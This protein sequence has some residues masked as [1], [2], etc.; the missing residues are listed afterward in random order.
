MA[1]AVESPNICIAVRPYVKRRG[2]FMSVEFARLGGCFSRY[3]LA[4]AG[5]LLTLACGTAWTQT[6][7]VG[8]V[9]GQVTDEQGAVIPGTE[10]KLTDLG[11]NAALTT[12]SND[13]GRYTFASVNPGK[14]NV[15]FTKQ[16]FATF[17][18]AQQD[19][20]IGQV[21]TINATLK[22]GTT[23]TTVEVTASSGAELQTM[24]ATVGNTLN[25]QS[26]IL[27]P[28]LGRDVTTLA[29]LQPATT[30][31]GYTAG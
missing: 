2:W 21:L 18:V 1:S 28:N 11:T 29:V 31:G 13:V 17:Q 15:T 22:V 25:G 20:Q 6:S 10:V 19:V 4:T 3:W 14:Y 9:M 23:A 16:G 30:L 7:S 5:M 27:M 26:L 8:T 24:N 12:L